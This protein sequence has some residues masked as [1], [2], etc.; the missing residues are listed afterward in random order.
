MMISAVGPYGGGD[1]FVIVYTSKIAKE[2]VNYQNNIH[3]GCSC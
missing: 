2:R 3:E 1:H